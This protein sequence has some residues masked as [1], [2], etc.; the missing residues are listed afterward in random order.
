VSSSASISAGIKIRLAAFILAI[1]GGGRFDWLDCTN[2][3]RV[4]ENCATD[5]RPSKSTVLKIADHIQ[6]N[7]LEL[8]NNILRYSLSGTAMTGPF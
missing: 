4:A 2:S 6:E 8:N 3:W 7:I 1:A 5:L